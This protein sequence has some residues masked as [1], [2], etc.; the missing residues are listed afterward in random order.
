MHQA[1]REVLGTHVEQ[2]GSL[3][4][5]EYLRF[6]FSHFQKVTEEEIAKIESLVNGRIQENFELN[7]YRAIP[8][9]KAEEKGAM[10]LFG[11]KY[12][13]V[14]RMIE[15]GESREL[16]G[17]I[18][19]E[20][21][22][23][24]ELFKIKSEGSV[25]S[26]IRRIEALT[27]KMATR[28]L[29]EKVTYLLTALEDISFVEDYIPK[30][31]VE[32]IE[33]LKN[34]NWEPI[35]HIERNHL[36][37]ISKGDLVSENVEVSI[38]DRFGLILSALTYAKVPKLI[39]DGVNAGK[40][41]LAKELSKGNSEKSGLVKEQLLSQIELIRGVNVIAQ[42]ITLTDSSAIK[43]LA[44]Q[45]KAQV[46]NLFLVLGAEV[47]GKPNLTIVVSEELAK[48]KDLH[49]GNIV[50]EAAKEMRGGG[51]GQPFYATAGGSYLAGINAAIEKAKSVL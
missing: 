23:E 2:K 48:T 51:G 36:F 39:I 44:F 41:K 9:Q 27:S 4:N 33:A 38:F 37:S 47:N 10:M 16:C 45:L 7:E 18:H 26:G 29:D 3:V 24:I 40:K 5:S 8:I 6:D 32:K 42:K 34:K 12:G 19:V 17:G 49:A 43:D 28:F 20:A 21:T 15:F 25:A 14:V 50:R 31:I 35:K 30:E 11:E 13:D 22:A 1:L 46:D